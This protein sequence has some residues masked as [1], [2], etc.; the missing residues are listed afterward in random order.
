[1]AGRM[2][3]KHETVVRLHVSEP[4]FN[5]S[6]FELLV[7]ACEF[8]KLEDRVRL[9]ARA[10][11]VNMCPCGGIA[12]TSVLETEFCRCKSCRGYQL[13]KGEVMTSY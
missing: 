3:L 8:S 1:M 12:Y 11:K 13:L 9:P 6:A 7:V 5:D 10:P 4:K 2:S